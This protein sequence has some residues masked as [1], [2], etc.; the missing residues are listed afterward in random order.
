MQRN[1]LIQLRGNNTQRKI[2]EQ[3]GISQNFYSWIE[4]GDRTPS[5]KVAK[6]IANILGFDWTLFYQEEQIDEYKPN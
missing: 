2:A 1:W 3:C 6:K 4:S 5:V